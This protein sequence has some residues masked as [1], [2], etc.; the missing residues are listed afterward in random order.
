MKLKKYRVVSDAYLGFEAQCW[1]W[2]FPFWM[3]MWYNG[4]T[5]TFSTKEEAINYIK[6]GAFVC[7]VN[8]Q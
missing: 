3:E 5:N 6:H 1:R 7:N 8:K 2:W 4:T